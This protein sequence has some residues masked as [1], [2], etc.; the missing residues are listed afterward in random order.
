MNRR[1]VPVTPK[2]A[3]ARVA[4]A[5]HP[6]S[7]LVITGFKALDRF[8]L[9]RSDGMAGVVHASFQVDGATF[10]RRVEEEQIGNWGVQWVQIGGKRYQLSHSDR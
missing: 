6:H 9:T 10:T 1:F 4:A 5:T 3:A 8:Y 7:V 2:D